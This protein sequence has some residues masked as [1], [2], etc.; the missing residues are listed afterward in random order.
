MFDLQRIFKDHLWC[1]VLSVPLWRSATVCQTPSIAH[2]IS[3]TLIYMLIEVLLKWVY[4][5]MLLQICSLLKYYTVVVFQQ[6]I[7]NNKD[8]NKYEGW[9]EVVEMEGCIPQKQ[10]WRGENR[11]EHTFTVSGKT[12]PEKLHVNILRACSHL[13]VCMSIISFDIRIIYC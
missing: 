5:I 13:G 8:T 7:K 11:R 12:L 4:L 9:P 2:L 1:F 10:D 3:W 6:H